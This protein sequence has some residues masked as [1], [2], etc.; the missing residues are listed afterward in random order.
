MNDHI[1]EYC[2]KPHDGTYGSGRFCSNTCARKYSNEYVTHQGRLNQI[3]SLNSKE[4][5]AKALETRI[6]HPECNIRRNHKQIEYTLYRPDERAVDK[7]T[8]NTGLVGKIGEVTTIKKFIENG[9]QVYTP[10]L[11]NTKVDLVAEFDGKLQRVQVKSSSQCVGVDNGA[12]RFKLL[13]VGNTFNHGIAIS[14]HT[15]YELDEVDYFA[16]YDCNED[17]VYLIKNKEGLQK[18]ITL[19]HTPPTGGQIKH[20][21]YASDYQ[22]DRYL[23]L[24]TM[25]YDPE[26]M[27]E[28]IIFDQ[29]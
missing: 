23:A 16:L 24:L 6:N 3:E 20:I 25:G 26:N 14:K 12:T 19:R 21:N 7:S 13:S 27:V 18:D 4:N 29:E 11:D 5:R 28:P 15:P 17:N 2:R 10:I 22:I 1:C 9:I 8:N